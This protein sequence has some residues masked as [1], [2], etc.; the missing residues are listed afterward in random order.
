[1]KKYNLTE[2]DVAELSDIDL[3]ELFEDVHGLNGDLYE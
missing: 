1:M 3:L 2:D